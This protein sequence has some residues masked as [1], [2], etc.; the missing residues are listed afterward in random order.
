LRCVFC[1]RCGSRLWHEG[2]P[3]GATISVKGGS[4]DDPPDLATAIH[5]WTSRKLP[6][7]VIPPDRPLFS[8]EPSPDSADSSVAVGSRSPAIYH[9][10]EDNS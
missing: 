8:E 10:D 9:P 7:V 4:L 3:K 1:P 5:I 6:G 2:E